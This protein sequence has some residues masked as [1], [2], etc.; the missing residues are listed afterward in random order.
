MRVLLRL[1][2]L[3]LLMIG[4][5]V[6]FGANRPETVKSVLVLSPDMGQT[7]Y[8]QEFYTE[9]NTQLKSESTDTEKVVLFHENL[10][11]ALFPQETHRDSL[12]RWL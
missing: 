8:L 7:T 6:A 9:L 4:N 2:V 1:S 11:L 5:A 10:D 3:L 12:V